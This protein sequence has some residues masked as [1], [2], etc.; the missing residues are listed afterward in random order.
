MIAKNKMEER[1]GWNR[2]KEGWRGK[3]EKRENKK[4]KKRV[5]VGEERG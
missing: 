2:K 3:I 5:G 4:G 1:L